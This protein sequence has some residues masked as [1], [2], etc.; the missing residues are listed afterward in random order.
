MFN[1]NNSRQNEN[2]K[3][4]KTVPLSY[5]SQRKK[6]NCYCGCCT[7]THDALVVVSCPLNTQHP[8]AGIPIKMKKHINIKKKTKQ[9]VLTCLLFLP[10]REGQFHY[11]QLVYSLK[12]TPFGQSCCIA[13]HCNIFNLLSSS[14]QLNLLNAFFFSVFSLP[15][16]SVFGSCRVWY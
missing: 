15:F 5:V 9:H 14:T 10:Y 16:D 3:K 6:N 4:Q 2:K 1:K 11:K 12:A 7:I 8:V 13:L